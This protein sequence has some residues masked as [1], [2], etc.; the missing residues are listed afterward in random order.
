MN[1]VSGEA[2]IVEGKIN[3]AQ[4][5]LDMTSLNTTD[6]QITILGDVRGVNYFSVDAY[7]EAKIEIRSISSISQRAAG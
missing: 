3:T 2:N 6:E 4:I 1:I 7:P 5:T